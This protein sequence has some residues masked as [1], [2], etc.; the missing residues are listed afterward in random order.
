MAREFSFAKST[1]I[2]WSFDEIQVTKPDAKPAHSR[3]RQKCNDTLVIPRASLLYKGW[4][5]MSAVLCVVS[6]LDYLDI[7]AYSKGFNDEE[8]W[9]LARD[10]AYEVFFAADVFFG[11]FSEKQAGAAV[12]SDLCQIFAVYF[13]GELILDVIP[14][15][16]IV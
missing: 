4:T 8:S 11:F 6:A 15:L 12:L 13:K 10:L 7:L 14:L 1:K 5:V 9:F 2:Q 16:P 3:Q